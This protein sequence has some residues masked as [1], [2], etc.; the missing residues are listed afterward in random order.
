MGRTLLAM[1]AGVLFSSS[2]YSQVLLLVDISNPANVTFTTTGLGAGAEAS[3]QGFL[4]VTLVGFFDATASQ[5]VLLTGDLL[6]N[7]MTLAY[8]TASPWTYASGA[9]SG[10]DLNLWRSSSGI[11][12]FTTPAPAFTGTSSGDFSLVEALLPGHGH[13]GFIYLGDSPGSGAAIL[14]TYAVVPEPAT[15]IFAAVGGTVVLAFRR[16]RIA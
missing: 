8:A 12:D 7:G 11:Q 1:I 14:G 15:A 10:T 16:R 5:G 9:N 6:A 2:A 3:A 13:S 4:G